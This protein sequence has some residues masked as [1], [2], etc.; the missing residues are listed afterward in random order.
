MV[1]KTEV[2]YKNDDLDKRFSS[3]L[4]PKENEDYSCDSRHA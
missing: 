3:L 2:L 4:K 1:Y